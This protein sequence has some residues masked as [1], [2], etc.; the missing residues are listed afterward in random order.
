MAILINSTVLSHPYSDMN[1]PILGP[2]FCPSKV[3]YKVVN[4]SRNSE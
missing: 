3:S 2:Y 4:Q 1:D